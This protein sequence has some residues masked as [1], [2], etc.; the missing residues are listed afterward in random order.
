MGEYASVTLN[1][2]EYAGIY[3]K[4]QNSE[5]ATILNVSDSVHGIRSL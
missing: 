2:I 4:N 1:M 3:L 5:Y